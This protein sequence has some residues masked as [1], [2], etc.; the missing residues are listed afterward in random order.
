MLGPPHRDIGGEL[1]LDEQLEDRDEL[2]RNQRIAATHLHVQRPTDHVH[3]GDTFL[4]IAHDRRERT[5]LIG[6]LQEIVDPT[7]Q[8]PVRIV[9][10]E[11]E[12]D[13]RHPLKELGCAGSRMRAI[14]TT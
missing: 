10:R 9:L 7:V 1:L 12:I 8:N 5:V 14:S 6:G 13:R 11:L 2:V 3:V 4:D